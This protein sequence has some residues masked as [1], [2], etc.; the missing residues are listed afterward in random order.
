[1]TT[2]TIL[3]SE[4]VVDTGFIRLANLEVEGAGERFTRLVV[5]HPGAVV[6]VPVEPDREHVLLVRQY[7]AA[8][9][10]E[11]LEVVAGKRDVE[12]EAPETTAT[13]EMHEEIGRRPGRLVKLCE[14]YNSPGFCDEYTHL[15]AALDL[16][17]LDAPAAVNAE[18]RE[19]TVERVRLGD[20]DDLVARGG[21]VDA[22][23][24]AG[25]LLTQRYLAGEFGGFRG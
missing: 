10:R 14:F 15:Y 3:G 21:I 19:L 20:V 8:A 18:E 12:G 11:L 13:R 17:E 9:D 7:R 25:L 5:R 6:V 16:D 2:F 23:S 22:K 1:M 4:T 24:I